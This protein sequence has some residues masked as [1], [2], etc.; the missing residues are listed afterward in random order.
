MRKPLIALSLALS[1]GFGA[2]PVAS[3]LA[4]SP[5]GTHPSNSPTPNVSTPSSTTP[6]VSTY[7]VRRPNSVSGAAI[8][9]FAY[10]Y[11]GYPYT[12]TGNSPSTGFSCIGFA[13]Y[14]YRS[15]GIPL[16]GD[17]GNAYAYAPQVPFSDLLPGDL[18]YFQDTVW[19]GLSH[20]AIYIGNGQF[21][22]AEYYGKGVRISSF[23]G[24]PTDGDY[25]IQ[26]YM[27]ANR[28][29]SGPAVGTVPPPPST[30]AAKTPGSTT[31]LPST[32]VSTNLPN[33]PTAIVSVSSLNVRSGPSKQSAVQT[34]VGQGT[35]VTVMVRRKNWTKVALPDGTVGWVV[36]IGIGGTTASPDAAAT[37]SVNTPV[38]PA[39]QGQPATTGSR[40]GTVKSTVTGLRV[41]SSPSVG[42]PVVTS[43]RNGE[44]MTVIRRSG[45]WD[46]VRLPNGLTGWISASYASTPA[47][48]AVI[49]PASATKKV[50]TPRVNT[51]S[52]AKARVSVN[53][54]TRP[55]LKGSVVTVLTPGSGYRVLGWSNGWARV[56]LANG[57]VGWVS[58]SALGIK[59]VATASTVKN[60]YGYSGPR[61][62]VKKVAT[63]KSTGPN[64]VTA[65]V[66]VHSRPGVKA[67]I[68]TS[69]AAGT[70][71]TVI[72]YRGNWKLV[73]LP[74]GM[75]GYIL[76]I[77]VR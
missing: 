17:L 38:A 69:A 39:R 12:A 26:H 46:E 52:S 75:T 10:K 54:R 67:P 9:A 45:G 1:A 19:P 3:A 27:G 28:P 8:V 71:V 2:V 61:T 21:V 14:V 64:V 22:H 31:K 66:N 23:K 62:P 56:R 15:L 7:T 72:G 42:A 50:A 11:L 48:A 18:L 33:G 58:G 41:H 29:W 70:H 44:K 37:V 51:V 65:G 5:S 74:N 63:N 35:T 4:A 36:N 40:L 53:V 55:S 24:D 43:V 34:V 57:T 30:S 60:S 6:G 77:Y 49:T 68:I 16:P 32:V 13:S 73:R 47:N 76:G 59:P 20:V 25:W